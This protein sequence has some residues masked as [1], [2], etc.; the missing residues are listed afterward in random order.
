MSNVDLTIFVLI[1]SPFHFR[2]LP[3]RDDPHQLGILPYLGDRVRNEQ[4][5]HIAGHA[6]RLPPLLATFDPVLINDVERV[7]KSALGDLEC[8]TV[9]TQIRCRFRWIPFENQ[10]HQKSCYYIFVSTSSVWFG[11]PVDEPRRRRLGIRGTGRS[12]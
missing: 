7:R 12:Q 6:Q 9:L 8:D 2:S 11:S 5:E 3:G 1:A 4:Q 10:V